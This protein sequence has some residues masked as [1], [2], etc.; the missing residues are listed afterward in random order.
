MVDR[1]KQGRKY[2]RPS[3]AAPRGDEALRHYLN[4]ELQNISAAMNSD[5]ELNDDRDENCGC[6]P[7]CEEGTA[8]CVW[9]PPGPDNII[10]ESVYKETQNQYSLIN[11]S[12]RYNGILGVDGLNLIAFP[13][14]NKVV[15][16]SDG[17][18]N[19]TTGTIPLYADGYRATT[20][21][22]VNGLWFVDLIDTN[23]AN[24]HRIASTVDGVTWTIDTGPTGLLYNGRL[25]FSSMLQDGGRL[26][27]SG[28]LVSGSN[29]NHVA[30]YS[31]PYGS[32]AEPGQLL[33]G[34]DYNSNRL[35]KVGS[36]Y[37][38][39]LDFGPSVFFQL[40]PGDF[41]PPVTS[42]LNGDYLA[43][44]SHGA[45]NNTDTILI[46]GTNNLVLQWKP[47]ADTGVD[48]PTVNFDI[49]PSGVQRLIGYQ[50]LPQYW[51]ITGVGA[52]AANEWDT[53]YSEDADGS[54]FTKGPTLVIPENQTTA[55]SE[56]PTVTNIYPGANGY[57]YGYYIATDGFI[58]I[59]RY[60]YGEQ[61]GD[62]TGGGE[63]TEGFNPIEGDILSYEE[64]KKVWCNDQ[65]MNFRFD[66]WVPGSTYRI[67]DTVRDGQWVMVANTVTTDRPAPQASNDPVW[68]S[69][70]FGPGLVLA[71]LTELEDAWITGNEY[72]FTAP[73]GDADYV[74]IEGY[75]WY[76]PDV[77]GT[78]TYDVW[79]YDTGGDATQLIA[80]A[81]PTD[82]G[83]QS[84]PASRIV[85]G[86]RIGLAVVVRAVTQANSFSSLWQTKNENSNPSEGEAIFRNNATEIRVS[87]T[88]K[89]D[90]NQEANLQ[91]IE[92]GATLSFAGST[93][94]VTNITTNGSGGGGRHNFFIEPNQ[95][96]P[97]ED[98]YILTWTWGATD[99]VPY[100]QDTDYYSG[101]DL[102]YGFKSGTFPPLSF[103]KNG[104][105]VDLLVDD[106]IESEDWDV[107]VP[108]P[109]AVVA[110]TET[111]GE[112]N[113]S[114]NVGSGEG[115]ALAKV[116]V[117][118]PF[119]SLVAGAN[120]TLTPGADTVTIAATGNGGGGGGRALIQQITNATA[121]EFDFQ[122]IP[123]TYE[124]LVL[125]GSF[126]STLGGSDIDQL[127]VNFNGDTDSLNY[128]SGESGANNGNALNAEYAYPHAGY[129][130]GANVPAGSQVRFKAELIGYARTGALQQM[131]TWWGYLR[132]GSWMVHGHGIVTH[133][134]AVT[135]I[136]RIRLFAPAA[137]LVGYVRLYGEL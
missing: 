121:G 28:R 86:I 117:N 49:A 106:F 18:Q 50:Q 123:G 127:Y 55:G 15:T 13:G 68:A 45:S 52:G 19:W 58:D 42:W 128:F 113:T 29:L 36:D 40:Y 17:G 69:D 61:T 76:C 74:N 108:P 103:D 104:Y 92:V 33:S 109:S 27:F 134:T 110:P 87:N 34:S 112:A 115:L 5:S 31:T 133:E 114:S 64:D 118:L 107:M 85:G 93:W 62:C 80:G 124:K 78:F 130:G 20:I 4:R 3:Q 32:S 131:Q 16:S 12:N 72:D 132:T 119:K 22:Y 90:V 94:T 59:F 30:G 9:T 101:T 1:R 23:D 77:S 82:V 14:G 21:Q 2:Y 11:D 73:D 125:E 51:H 7:L 135:A 41:T 96:R 25:S 84:I 102:V 97:T 70:N 48:L 10:G 26:V 43:D 46:P 122:S 79:A 81:Q 100:V 56:L 95:G 105:G 75:R 111:E 63:G 98:E 57:W 137:G 24:A 54:N 44:A 53:W 8:P 66:G 91:A 120:V 67:Q 89:N 47:T 65:R 71:T 38:A 37:V 126:I 6:L 99:P 35:W 136:N 116:G 83:W 39:L 88:D 60:K 129:C